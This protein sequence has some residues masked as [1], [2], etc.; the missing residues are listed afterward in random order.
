MPVRLDSLLLEPQET[1]QQVVHLADKAK[2]VGYPWDM[3]KEDI[4]FHFPEE[5]WQGMGKDALETFKS[6]PRFFLGATKIET[7]LR[8]PLNP[9]E[10]EVSQAAARLGGEILKTYTRL[11]TA[12]IKTTLPAEG[13]SRIAGAVKGALAPEETPLGYAGGEIAKKLNPDFW[14]FAGI[15]GTGVEFGAYLLPGQRI[16]KDITEFN[17]DRIMERVIRNH[18]TSEGQTYVEKYPKIMDLLKSKFGQIEVRPGITLDTYMSSRPFR[19]AFRNIVESLKS[20]VGEAALPKRISTF[21][22]PLTQ[23]GYIINLIAQGAKVPQDLLQRLGDMIAEQRGQIGMSIFE[24]DTGDIEKMTKLATQGKLKLN[25]NPEVFSEEAHKE[26]Y[27]PEEYGKVKDYA[28]LQKGGG[29]APQDKSGK[30]LVQG[31]VVKVGDKFGIVEDVFDDGTAQ[32]KTIV[33]LKEVPMEETSKVKLENLTKKEQG[34]VESI[35]GGELIKL[36]QVEG[37]FEMPDGSMAAD[38]PDN[39]VRAGQMLKKKEKVTLPLAIRLKDGTIIIEETAKLHSDIL[40]NKKINPDDVQDVGIEVK[41]EY[42]ATKLPDE[43]GGAPLENLP[44]VPKELLEKVKGVVSEA[45]K[46]TV[47]SISK[48]ELTPEILD[49]LTVSERKL[50]TKRVLEGKTI[51][52]TAKE[53]GEDPEDVIKAENWLTEKIP[54]VKREI[55]KAKLLE[56]EKLTEEFEAEMAA[57]TDETKK[58]LKGYLAGKLKPELA[59][60]GEY[61]DLKHLKWLFAK[62]GAKGFTPDELVGELQEMGFNV[63]GDNDV[64]ELIKSYFSEEIWDK[65]ERAVAGIEKK[66]KD[67]LQAAVNKPPSERKKIADEMRLEKLNVIADQLTKLAEVAPRL[68]TPKQIAYIHVLKEKNL[69]SDQQFARLKKIFTG[70]KSLKVTTPTGRLKKA[71]VTK[72]EAAAFVEGM[73]GIVPKK[74]IITG[75]PPVIPRT[76]ALVPSEWSG[77]FND[78]TT[79]Q[80]APLSGL[81]PI[82]AAELVDGKSYGPVKKYIVEPAQEAERVWKNELKSTLDNLTKISKGMKSNSDESEQ[83]FKFI[84]KTLEPGEEAKITETMRKTADYLSQV[85][86]DLLVRINEKRAL[87][88]KVPIQKRQDY[89]THIWELSLMDEF[90]QGLSN[91]PD[92]VVNIPSYAKSNSPFF[93]FALARLGGKEFRL[94]AIAAF[95]SY[96]SRAYPIIYN[97][98]VLKSAR[99]LVDRLPSNAYKY[100]TQYLDETMALRPAQADKLIPKPLLTAISWLRRQ[101]G[102]GAILGNLAS[103]FNQLFTIPNSVSAIGPK[104]VASAVLKMHRDEWRAFTEAHSKVLQS[105]IYEIDF[106]PTLLSKVDN[107]LGFLIQFGDKEM[108][109][110]AWGAQFEKSLSKG[111]NFGDAIKDADNMAFKTQSGFN[112]TDLPPAFRSK[113]AGSFLQFQNTVNN[114]LNFLRFD[115][116]KEEDKRGKMGVFKAALL[117]LGTLL[118]LNKIYRTLGIPTPIDEWTDVFPLISMAEYGSPATYSAPWAIMQRVLAKTPQDQAGANRALYRSAF[119]FL[120]AGNQFRK[121]LEG[122]WAVSQGGKFD[123]RGRLLIPIQGIPE[124][125]R[126]VAFGPYGTKAGQAY[127]KRGFKPEAGRNFIRRDS[128]LQRSR[129]PLRRAKI[130][131]SG[132]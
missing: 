29:I 73:K 5:K 14:L 36:K 17:K 96:T 80:A 74:P 79:F 69:L 77:P 37:F 43:K 20:E 86:D 128:L 2:N 55:E 18:L 119:L 120:P 53:L 50:A 92:D 112:T 65:A 110:I 28:E 104:F 49:N 102:K 66:A 3:P 113:I 121:T 51:K 108:V 39:R 72:E 58:A 123:K 38:T 125:A 116:G 98:D 52:K 118:V 57:E 35:K 32:L 1:E 23:D 10:Q 19:T 87:L 68:I 82:R 26:F 24:P 126:A 131:T 109:R 54:E 78:L 46:E 100:F 89:I 40:I 132:Q 63:E 59:T 81:D 99:P 117:W 61:V 115:L 25:K 95:E 11:P 7:D 48:E 103:V 107:A 129:E 90:F 21:K 9:E 114:G 44:E 84:E 111:R 97:T 105:R 122:I 33:G 22:Q 15:L 60:Q 124:V 62:E 93:K 42:Q 76:K 27:S 4:S 56:D 127:I 94:D 34:L 16:G 130:L 12:I 91:I 67:K 85:Y 75:Q 8:G 31:D 64:R 71:P 70:K 30:S 6:I 106:D 45:I 41:G 101:M 83:V 13:E 88:N 47:A